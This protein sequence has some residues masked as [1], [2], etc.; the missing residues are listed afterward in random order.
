MKLPTD[1]GKQGS[2]AWP[3]E[4]K[5]AGQALSAAPIAFVP[6]GDHDFAC[7]MGGLGKI[8]D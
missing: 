3:L 6:L 4:R 7:H 8:A 5:R 2:Q 1:G